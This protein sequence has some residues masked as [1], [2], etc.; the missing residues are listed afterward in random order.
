M[1]DILDAIAGLEMRIQT[2]APA[3]PPTPP[4]AALEK[5][6]AMAEAEGN[7]S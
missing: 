4:P 2:A 5:A 6:R 3:L 7:G 1:A